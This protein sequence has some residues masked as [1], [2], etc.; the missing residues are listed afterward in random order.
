MGLA[1]IILSFPRPSAA[2]TAIKA[3]GIAD[4]L[5]DATTRHTEWVERISSIASRQRSAAFL[6]EEPPA[7][8]MPQFAEGLAPA[9]FGAY[10][11]RIVI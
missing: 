3:I 10:L 6:D 2:R 11:Q 1:Y 7:A 8:D 9:A 4:D 5:A